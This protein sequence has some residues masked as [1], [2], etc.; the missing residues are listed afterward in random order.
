[1][2]E[3]IEKTQVEDIERGIYDI[4]E[5]EDHKFTTNQG[6]NEEVVREIKREF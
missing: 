2:E 5:K 6:L 3:K 4:I 1:M